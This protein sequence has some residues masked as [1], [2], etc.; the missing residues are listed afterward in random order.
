MNCNKNTTS[1]CVALKT[2][3]LPF[4]RVTDLL[5]K[6]C[7][8]VPIGGVQIMRTDTYTSTIQYGIDQMVSLYRGKPVR[9]NGLR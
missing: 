7:S 9:R 3:D 6:H 2:E 8:I 4:A 1:T 5:H